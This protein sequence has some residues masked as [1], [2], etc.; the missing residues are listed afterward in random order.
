MLHENGRHA[1]KSMP[2]N[3]I[4][5]SGANNLFLVCPFC[6]I[7]NFIVKETGAVFFLTAPAAI[8]HIYDNDFFDPIDRLIREENISHL[9]VVAD[10]SCMFVRNVLEN[11]NKRGIAC[12]SLI[13]ELA[14]DYDTNESLAAKV[15]TQEI[16]LLSR[17]KLF[18]ERIAAGTLS[19][20]ALLTN[21]SDNS[22]TI[23]A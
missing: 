21:K 16:Q 9:Y 5:T 18:A 1:T 6:Q 2:A 10:T 19:M 23:I 22:I 3:R 4:G 14:T 8:F 15:V 17:K 7:E 12:E 11:R 20:Y 13:R